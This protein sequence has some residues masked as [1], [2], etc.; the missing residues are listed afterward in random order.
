[1]YT[2]KDRQC[3]ERS[4][5]LTNS[6]QINFETVICDHHLNKETWT[7]VLNGKLV[8]HLDIR[9]EAQEYKKAF[10]WYK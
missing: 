7:P 4:T 1:M 10:N 6:Y 2:V 3:Q 5:L 8:A 9:Q